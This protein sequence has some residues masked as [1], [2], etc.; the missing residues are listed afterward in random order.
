MKAAQGCKLFGAYEALSGIQDSVVLL[1]SVVGCNF[2]TMAFHAACDMAHIRQTCTVISDTEVVFGGEKS[3][4]KA[5]AYVEELFQPKVIFVIT[6]CISDMIQDDVRSVAQSHKGAAEVVFVEA[7]GYRGKMKEGQEAAMKALTDLAE[8]PVI[9][10]KGDSK[11]VIL[12]G[13]GADDFCLAGDTKALQ[14]LAGEKIDLRV[15]ANTSAEELKK[16]ASA[17]LILTVG[18]GEAYGKRMNQKYGIPWKALDYPYGLTGAQ[19]MW[20][21]LGE[22]FGDIDSAWKA[23]YEKAEDTFRKHT[24]ETLSKVYSY[25]QA[26]YSMPAAVI[27][28]ASRCR[29]MKRFLEQE[30][31]MEVV[32]CEEREQIT[33]LEYFYAQV[34]QSEAAVLFGSSFEKELAEELEIPL[35]R[36]DYPVFD[37]LSLSGR[38]YVGEEGSLCLVEDILNEIMAARN[39]K[40]ALYQ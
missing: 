33:D 18:Y 38:C 3:L 40:G 31:G 1:H 13:L 30:L 2:G 24:G 16:A 26:L 19:E 15:L 14:K 28:T 4:K 35:V 36:F 32:V 39:R 17:D 7:A 37:R 6:G 25:L 8:V 10:S 20:K 5:L 23:A 22:H 34:R 9:F 12:A 29:G 27:G 21:I 11:K